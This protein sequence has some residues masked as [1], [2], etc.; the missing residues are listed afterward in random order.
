MDPTIRGALNEDIQN[1]DLVGLRNNGTE[2]RYTC[3]AQWHDDTAREI[4]AHS[5]FARQAAQERNDATAT[6]DATAQQR[7]RDLTA[8][9]IGWSLGVAT[10]TVAVWRG[11]ITP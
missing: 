8:A 9:V 11:W 1:F 10:V 4:L 5:W 6:Y 3:P 2:R 7:I